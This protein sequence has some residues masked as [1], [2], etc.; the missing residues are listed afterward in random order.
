MISDYSPDSIQGTKC[1]LATECGLA[2]GNPQWPGVLGLS[3]EAEISRSNFLVDL[4]A[5]STNCNK[6]RQVRFGSLQN[7]LGKKRLNMNPKPDNKSE[8]RDDISLLSEIITNP[9]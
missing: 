6:L 4:K 9:R 8:N 1:K 7:F 5:Q 2:R 3:S